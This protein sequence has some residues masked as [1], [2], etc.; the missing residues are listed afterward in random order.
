ML[1]KERGRVSKERLEYLS[2]HKGKAVTIGGLE[3]SDIATELLSLRE[4]LA[5]WKALPPFSWGLADKDGNAYLSECCIGDEGCMIDEAEAEAYNY[6]LEPEHHIHAVP[7]FT[8]SKP[9]ED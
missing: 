2:V 9:A 4:Q 8:A 1:S 6:E 3:L 5:E 7:L